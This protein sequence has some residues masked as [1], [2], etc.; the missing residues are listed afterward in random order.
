LTTV[1]DRYVAPLR[2]DR[3]ALLSFLIFLALAGGVV[4]L[5]IGYW[6][7]DPDFGVFPGMDAPDGK[8]ETRLD[9]AYLREADLRGIRNASAD[10]FREARTLYKARLDPALREAIEAQ[11]PELLE[12]RPADVRE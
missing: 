6:Q 11:S 2:A 9:G 12:P 4:P 5:S 8:R 10:T 7:R 3:P 1:L